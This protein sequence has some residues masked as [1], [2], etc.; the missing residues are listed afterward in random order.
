MFVVYWYIMRKCNSFYK[1]FMPL[2][3]NFYAQ[4][5]FWPFGDAS[6]RKLRHCSTVRLLF[7][8]AVHCYVER[9]RNRYE[10]IRDFQITFGYQGRSGLEMTS[11]FLSSTQFT[12]SDLLN[13]LKVIIVFVLAGCSI[14]VSGKL[15]FSNFLAY[16]IA[17]F[18]G[19]CY[20]GCPIHGYTSFYCLNNEEI[21]HNG[22]YYFRQQNW[23]FRG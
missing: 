7:L 15:I 20:L 8:F 12:I 23:E 6:D 17:C 11:S 4:E 14:G 2:I 3:L 21:I 22:S 10:V 19:L 1:L 13:R 5:R 18:H 16:S 9:I